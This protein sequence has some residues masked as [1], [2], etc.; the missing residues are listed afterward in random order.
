[1]NRCNVTGVSADEDRLYEF[2]INQDFGYDSQ[3][4]DDM[5]FSF[6]LCASESAKFMSTGRQMYS[7]EN[8]NGNKTI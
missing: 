8:K 6:A 3:F 4:F 1:M 2:Y 5:T 7:I